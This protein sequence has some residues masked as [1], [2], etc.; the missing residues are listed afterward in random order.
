MSG[1]EIGEKWG[2]ELAAWILGKGPVEVDECAR[3]I[4]RG[5]KKKKHDDDVVPSMMKSSK[6]ED[7]EEVREQHHVDG[8]DKG[9]IDLNREEEGSERL[10]PGKGESEPKEIEPN[11]HITPRDG[12][13]Q[14]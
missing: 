12:P 9:G 3:E 7:G 2:E 10:G 14:V 8:K 6:D 4:L 13:H 1:D 5:P 11:E